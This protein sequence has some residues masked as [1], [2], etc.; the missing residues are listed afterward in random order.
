VLVGVSGEYDPVAPDDAESAAIRSLVIECAPLLLASDG[1]G[2]S[3]AVAGHQR[4]SQ[5]DSFAIPGA[6][7]YESSCESGSVV[8]QIH[9]DSGFW[10]DGFVLGCSRL[11][12]P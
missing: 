9:V 11:R 1:S 5:A 8:T 3:A 12:S 7:S 2:V 4:I 6:A 10:L